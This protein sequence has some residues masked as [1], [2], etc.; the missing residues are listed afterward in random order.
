MFF[1]WLEE[2]KED[3]RMKFRKKSIFFE[4][5]K[6]GK[7]GDRVIFK[8]KIRNIYVNNLVLVD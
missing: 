5:W 1:V 6:S 3:K 7:R 2:K 8:V 4:M